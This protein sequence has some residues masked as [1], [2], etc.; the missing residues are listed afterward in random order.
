ME[1]NRTN[2]EPNFAFSRTS[3]S[4]RGYTD[5]YT[6]ENINF[7][8]DWESFME[9]ARNT[10]VNELSKNRNTKIFFSINANMRQIA[11]GF[12]TPAI[13][14]LRIKEAKII[15]DGTNLNELYDQIMSEINERMEILQDVEGSGWVFEGIKN[16]EIL[17]VPYEPLR[18]SKYIELPEYIANKKAIINIKN[19]DEDCFKW[20]VLRALNPKKENPHRV[21]KQL[22][23]VADTINMDG[24]S[25]PTKIDDITKFE[26]QN[27]DI[28]VVVLG[29]NENGK[30]NT[31]RI[32][33]YTYERK[34][35][36]V[37]FLITDLEKDFHYTLVTQPSRL[38]SHQYTNHNGKL[39]FCW[40]CLN[41]F[42]KE[43]KFQFH[44]EQCMI[45]KTQNIIMPEEG[46]IVKFRKYKNT[47][48]HPF[49]VYADIECKTTKL[50][51]PDL[52]PES[53]Y[54][55]KTQYHEPASYVLRFLS[56]NQLVM[57][58]KTIIYVGED[59][60][61]NLV[62]ELEYLVSVIYN[63]PEAK[64]IYEREDKIIQ[65]NS[66]VCHLLR[67]RRN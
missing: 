17:T 35:L 28:A 43:E 65:A 13:K 64:H 33:E 14:N 15:L 32:S 61:D 6:A 57:E 5:K 60:M 44:K 36:V 21:D 58:N 20:C 9:T 54:T 42:H 40:N 29:L 12:N 2:V 56:Y 39:Y 62:E 18:G 10:I 25:S 24:I 67:T 45:N 7:T 30:I 34:H 41:V 27:L 47:T 66:N 53:S 19:K 48:Y 1:R 8:G 4:F 37:L 51:Y 49:V 59:C 52:N 22:K 63:K 38:I 3:A 46:S 31:I 11:G 26:K 23:A 55:I 50:E 16:I